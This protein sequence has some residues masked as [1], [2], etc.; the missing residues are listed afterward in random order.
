MK[1]EDILLYGGIAF[2]AYMLLK[3]KPPGTVVA[4]VTSAGLLPTS[5]AVPTNNASTAALST[6]LAS[7]IKNIFSPATPTPSA[8]SSGNPITAAQ[9]AT[10]NQQAAAAGSDVDTSGI[11]STDTNSTPATSTAANTTDFTNL[12]LEEME[13][14]FDPSS[15][16]GLQREY[17]RL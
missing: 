4:P 15:L 14:G 11:F 7:A 12:E 16:T 17:R 1:T 9:Q 6:S 3:P 10:L 2:A 8:A 5:T 13:G